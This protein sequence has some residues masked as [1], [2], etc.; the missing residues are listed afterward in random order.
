MVLDYLQ[1]YL[2]LIN[3]FLSFFYCVILLFMFLV[4]SVHVVI[5]FSS[6][7]ILSTCMVCHTPAI[8]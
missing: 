1:N 6:Y 5:G 8:K 7:S 4:L 2:N 3:T